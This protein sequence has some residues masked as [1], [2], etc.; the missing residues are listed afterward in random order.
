MEQATNLC[1][2]LLVPPVIVGLVAARAVGD[3]LVQLGLASEQLLQGQ[4]LPT[5]NV[6]PSPDDA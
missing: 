3:G 2:G 4:R 5:L 6:H 1:I